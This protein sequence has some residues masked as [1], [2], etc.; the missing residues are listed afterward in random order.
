MEIELKQ[1]PV[2]DVFDGYKDA[3]EDGVVGYHG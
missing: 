1:I 3:D 2:K